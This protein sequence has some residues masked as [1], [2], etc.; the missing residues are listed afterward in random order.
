[1]GGFIAGA[2]PGQMQAL[3]EYGE[4]I[5]LAFQI[6]DDLLDVEGDKEKLGKEVQK[7]QAAGKLTYPGL[8]GV[9]ESRARAQSL[10]REA[11]EAIAF[12]GPRGHLLS[13]LADF[14]V[15]RDR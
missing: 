7:D 3:Q 14:I 4:R 9:E 13:R 11:R 2:S 8:M 1:M 12:F 15:E 5:G 10:V 6:A